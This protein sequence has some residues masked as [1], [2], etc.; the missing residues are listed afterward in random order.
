M[1]DGKLLYELGKMDE[2]G[3]Q[4]ESWLCEEDPRNQAAL[5]YLSLVSEAKFT[6]AIKEH[7][8]TVQQDLSEVEQAWANPVK[9]E[10]L[11]R[12]ESLRAHQSHPHQPGPR[13][14]R[15]QTGS[16]PAG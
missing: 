16:H 2:A 12:A 1:H 15:Q 10:L 7:G 8:V 9:R 13:S 5:Y 6:Q 14:H 3:S 4:A 11:P